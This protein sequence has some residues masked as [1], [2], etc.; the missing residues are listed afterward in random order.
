V[1]P[2]SGLSLSNNPFGID[3]VTQA[4]TEVLYSAMPTKPFSGGR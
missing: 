1:A 3:G 2:G 4:K